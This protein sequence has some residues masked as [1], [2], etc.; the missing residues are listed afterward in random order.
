MLPYTALRDD[1]RAE[2]RILEF[3]AAV[4][5]VAAPLLR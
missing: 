1:P 4:Y 3:A 2:E 5:D